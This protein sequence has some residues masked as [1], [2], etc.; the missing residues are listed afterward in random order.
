V[1]NGRIPRASAGPEANPKPAPKSAPKSEP[2]P[3][4]DRGPATIR[5]LVGELDGIISA[6]E[7][8]VADMNY[9][10]TDEFNAHTFGRHPFDNGAYKVLHDLAERVEQVSNDLYGAEEERQSYGA[11]TAQQQTARTRELEE[12]TED[13]RA[14]Q[15]KDAEWERGA[16][17]RETAWRALPPGS[18]APG[19]YPD[20]VKRCPACGGA[21]E[22]INGIHRCWACF[23]RSQDGR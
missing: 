20:S 18:T 1:P 7:K 19:R 12:M 9:T 14:S 21:V 10:G 13:A 17:A 2:A 15:R 3:P 5:A 11:L 6:L 23:R 8:H 4:S 22:T 16:Q